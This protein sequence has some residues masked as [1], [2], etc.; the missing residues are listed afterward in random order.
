MLLCGNVIPRV[1]GSSVSLTVYE[2]VLDRMK[3]MFLSR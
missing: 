3:G 2:D 1:S